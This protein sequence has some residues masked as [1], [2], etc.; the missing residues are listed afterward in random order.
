MGWIC[1]VGRSQGLLRAPREALVGWICLVGSLQRALV[2]PMK[3]AHGLDLLNGGGRCFVA[4]GLQYGPAAAQNG[5][6]QGPVGDLHIKNEFSRK[7]TRSGK[8]IKPQPQVFPG[9]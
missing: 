9:E 7:I 4:K 3:G 1:L 2:G 5:P 8:V 6:S